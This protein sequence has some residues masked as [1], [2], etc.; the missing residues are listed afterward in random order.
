[1]GIDVKIQ[2][3]TSFTI[4]TEKLCTQQPAWE[5]FLIKIQTL[6]FSLE[7]VKLKTNL[8]KFQV[9]LTPTI[10]ILCA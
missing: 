1:M 4:Q 8:S 2:D 5:L 10:M 7:A 3:K 9:L 6:R